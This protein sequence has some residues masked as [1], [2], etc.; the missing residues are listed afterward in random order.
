MV[1]D[2]GSTLD[3]L[4]SNA[5]S[6]KLERELLAAME[7]NRLRTLLLG[8]ITHDLRTPLTIVIA[9]LSMLREGEFGDLS[10][11]QTEWLLRA[12]DAATRALE[13]VNDIFELAKIELG[14]LKLYKEDLATHE[15]LLGVYDIGLGMP[16]GKG[17]KL[18]LEIPA[19]LPA[20]LAD[21]DRIQQVIINLLSNAL[22]FTE[23]GKVT[24]H[25]RVS[26]ESNELIIGVRDT[27]RGIPPEE[28]GRLFQRFSQ[29]AQESPKLRQGTGLGLSICREL[30]EMHGGRIWV[31]SAPGLGSNFQFA[32]PLQHAASQFSES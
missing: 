17:V 18:T 2:A 11:E 6:E 32:L 29:L 15:F 13:L 25:A 16:W 30:V 28:V 23:N 14:G 21:P 7:T 22:R 24:L 20:L 5:H 27:G 3:V 19:E 1:T 10:T 4:S 9:T 31:D 8:N 26:P 12:R